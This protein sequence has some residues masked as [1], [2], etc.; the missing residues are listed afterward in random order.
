MHLRI[1]TSK[2]IEENA[3]YYYDKS[4]KSKRKIEGLHKAIKVSKKKL[5]SIEKEEKK[6]KVEYN[7]PPEQKWYMKFRWFISS[8]GFLCIGGRDAMTNEIVIKK[9]AEKG[10]LIFHTQI[11]GSP[12]FIVKAEGKVVPEQTREEA[13]IATASFSRAWREGLSSAEVYSI[14]PE[15]VKKE[16]GLPKGSFMISG[17]RSYHTSIIQLFIGKDSEGYLECSPVEKHFTLIQEGKVSDTAKKI[18]K[19]YKDKDKINYPLDDII[20]ILPGNCSIKA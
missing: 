19:Y 1:D 3:T 20:R 10:D 5:T 13:A 2:S 12:F 16:F 9:H 11:T 7:D 15:Q 18:Q 6:P 4:K 17:K 14:S 8:D